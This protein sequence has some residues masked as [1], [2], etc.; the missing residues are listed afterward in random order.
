M[1]GQDEKPID[2]QGIRQVHIGEG[3]DTCPYSHPAVTAAASYEPHGR[4]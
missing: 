1:T 2:S 3:K 4:M